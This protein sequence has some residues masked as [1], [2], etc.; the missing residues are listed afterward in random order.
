MNNY[1]RLENP[2]VKWVFSSYCILVVQSIA[3]RAFE[4]R[5][6]LCIER[7]DRTSIP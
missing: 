2:T 3:G 1:F 4:G 5:V 7:I 6:D